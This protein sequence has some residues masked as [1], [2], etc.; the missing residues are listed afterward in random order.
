MTEDTKDL[1]E[2]N[3]TKKELSLVTH[4]A[5]KELQK[6]ERALKENK[7]TDK[8]RELLEEKKAGLLSIIIQLTI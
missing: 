1:H 7:L 5:T 4:L 8:G 3:L 6:T 2:F